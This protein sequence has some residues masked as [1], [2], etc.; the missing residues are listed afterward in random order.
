MIR[1][2]RFLM[3]ADRGW[4]VGYFAQNYW[5]YDTVGWSSSAVSYYRSQRPSRGL[6]LPCTANLNQRMVIL[7]VAG[8]QK[9]KF[10]DHR[11]GAG[12]STSI[13]CAVGA[14]LLSIIKGAVYGDEMGIAHEH[15]EGLRL[16]RCCEPN[17]NA[18]F[19]VCASCDRGQR[20]CSEACRS[21]QRRN[22]VRAAG[23]RYQS[24]E[25]GKRAH[26]RRQRAYRERLSETSV[27]H[28]AMATTTTPPIPDR[29]ALTQCLI[30]GQWSRWINP[31]YRLVPRRRHR[32]RSA[33]VQKSTFSDDR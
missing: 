25:A 21:R 28:Q 7:C 19:A 15:I 27:T 6:P 18:M 8:R 4:Y 12:V 17:C 3:T 32:P 20:Y 29:H 9:T 11:P 2:L 13:I 23:Q 26:C 16:R 1:K 33:K 14:N 10:S 30:C 31:Y 5:G 24:S 22:Q